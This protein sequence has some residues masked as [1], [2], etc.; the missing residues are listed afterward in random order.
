MHFVPFGMRNRTLGPYLAAAHPLSQ[1]LASSLAWLLQSI[2]QPIMAAFDLMPELRHMVAEVFFE[3]HFD[4][5]E[6]R[7]NFGPGLNTTSADCAKAFNLWRSSG[8][9]IHY[10]P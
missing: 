8:L 3:W 2:E 10:W 9:R 6:M 7:M 5:P 4:A 1:E